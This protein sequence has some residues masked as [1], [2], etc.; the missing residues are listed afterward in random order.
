MTPGSTMLESY[1]VQVIVLNVLAR[2][3][4]Y[5]GWQLIYNDRIPT[6]II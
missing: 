3:T 4:R 1:D 5:F 2:K 6:G